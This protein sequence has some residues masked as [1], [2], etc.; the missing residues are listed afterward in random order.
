MATHP[1]HS[2][3][4]HL[5]K[6]DSN[7]FK[8]PMAADL[9]QKRIQARKKRRLTYDCMSGIV[10]GAIVVCKEGHSF[11]Q[12][13]RSEGQGLSLLSVISGRSSRVCQNCRD[14]DQE[15]TE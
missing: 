11:P 8:Y 4:L 1:T 2:L 15:T 3:R 6:V 7:T 9:I 13:G 12:V 14:F 5:T 10:K